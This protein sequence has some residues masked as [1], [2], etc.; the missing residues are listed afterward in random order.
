ME[1]GYVLNGRYKIRRVLGEGGMA[2]VYL[3]DDLILNRPVT[4][5]ILRLDLQNDPAS[6]RRFHREAM[7]LTELTNPNIVNIY[8]IDQTDD[9]MQYLVM[10]YV[11]GMDLKAYIKKNHKLPYERV[12]EIMEQILSAVE[13]AHAHNIIHR[14]LKPKNILI[15]KNGT[16]KITDFGIA[17]A[18]AEF[19]MT[20][21]NTLVGSVHYISPEQ[22][23]GSMV[24]KQSDIYSL[25]IILFE[26]LT[27]EVPYQGET[28]I[29]VALKHYRNDMP[30]VR[31]YDN[32]IPQSLE[33]VILHA[34]AKNLNDRYKTVAEM[35]D[36]LRTV[37]DE[38]RKNEK[39]WRPQNF[40]DEETK[41][42]PQIKDSFIDENL[43]ETKTLILSEDAIKKNEETTK[44]R[45]KKQKWSRKK[46]GITVGA[47]ILAL[48]VILVVIFALITTPK[49]ITMPDLRGMT[50]TQ[51][52]SILDNNKLEKGKVTEKYS[53]L[54]NYGQIVSTNPKQGSNVRQKTSV[55][56]VISKG[57]DK[58]P[59]GDY[60]GQNYDDVK[61]RLENQGVHVYKKLKYTDDVAKDSI[62]SQSLKPSAAVVMSQTTVTFTV[63]KGPIH[64]RLK[65]FSGMNKSQIESYAKQQNI[66]VV[67]QYEASDKFKSG[68]VVRQGPAPNAIVERGS[69]VIV[70]LA[71]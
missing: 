36:D 65:M 32:N 43:D 50:Q 53:N 10:E 41:I 56:L 28:A 52:E 18:V 59:F 63:S 20:Q 2:N 22:A 7:S 38:D 57:P 19:T 23:R 34:T 21:T 48:I 37:L 42:L 29:S 16:V 61:E 13:D 47:I 60:R 46:R 51:A 66:D 71:K 25:G 58:K 44:T 17:V 68:E 40:V 39:V 24:T 69:Q 33:N 30:S 4:V 9:G 54:Y 15:D 1:P 12:I 26:M 6:L 14:D 45:E 70:V 8:D 5:K 55:G 11:D 67:F 49:V 64:F 35:A 3:A 62:T 27:G 31:N